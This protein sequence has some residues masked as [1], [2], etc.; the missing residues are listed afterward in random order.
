MD[1]DQRP[2]RRL[3]ALDLL[4][5]EGLGD[6]V[7]PCAA[8]LLRDHD[9]EDPELRH[10]LD[11]LQV[12]LVVDVVLDR[13]GQHPLVHEPADRLLDQPLLVAELEVH[14]GGSL[15][16]DVTLPPETG[17]GAELQY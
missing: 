10:P 6:V 2:E 9:A 15:P 16:P 12:E 5:G 11:Q 3:A 7:E 1:G 14:G 17:A 8:V 4:A 13:H